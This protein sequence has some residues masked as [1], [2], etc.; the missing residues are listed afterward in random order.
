MAQPDFRATAAAVKQ[1]AFAITGDLTDAAVADVRDLLTENLAKGP[2]REAFIDAVINRLGEGGPLSEAHVETIFR[3]NVASAISDGTNKA[4]QAPMVVDAFPYR[5]YY[6]TTDTRVRKEHLQLERLGLD[7]TNIYRADD[8]TWQKFRPPWDWGCR[9]SWVPL[10]VEQAARRGVTEAKEWLA[11]AQA[12]A[13]QLGGSA[14]EY[15]NR[16]E[17]ASPAWV[18]SPPFQPPAEFERT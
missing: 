7:G 15:I 16:T 17:P 13:D 3:T 2:D 14:A 9:C 8:P 1:G 11:R 10:T 6:A 18:Q 12:M 4:L 5:A